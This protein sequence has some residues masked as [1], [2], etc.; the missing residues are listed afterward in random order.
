MLQETWT[1]CNNRKF[2]RPKG[3]WLSWWLIYRTVYGSQIWQIPSYKLGTRVLRA[4]VSVS[5]MKV[6]VSVPPPVPHVLK[7]CYDSRGWNWWNVLVAKGRNVPVCNFQ[8]VWAKGLISIFTMAAL[9][10][11]E[12]APA[13][14]LYGTCGAVDH[15]EMWTAN[16][17]TC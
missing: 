9:N 1:T 4:W 16:N 14:F 8:P 3:K 15:V 6:W 10:S 17:V 12:C 5:C 2:E 13:I 7:M 11:P